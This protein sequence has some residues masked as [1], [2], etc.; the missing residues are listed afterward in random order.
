M[1]KL[2]LYLLFLLSV[3]PLL[4]S[5]GGDDSPDPD[6][7]KTDEQMA[8]EALTGSSNINWVVANGG[9]VTKDGQSAADT[10]SEFELR[11]ATGETNK[12][13]TT[14]SNPL[15][16]Q[17]GNWSFAGNNFDK[18]QLT[19]TQPAA[20][21]EISFTRTDDKLILMF[22]VPVPANGRINA[23]AGSYVFELVKN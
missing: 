12:T 7:E 18:I 22:T 15:F 3:G 4:V 13:Y 2:L 20:G 8:I 14:T 5:C 21:K 19:G 23:L 10:Y 1:Q 9:S 6:K 16:D 17:N 11:L